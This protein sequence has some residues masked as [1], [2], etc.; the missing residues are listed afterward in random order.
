MMVEIV[1]TTSKDGTLDAKKT[2]A[3]VHAWRNARMAN[4]VQV[5]IGVMKMLSQRVLVM[6]L[7]AHLVEFQWLVGKVAREDAQN[8][9]KMTVKILEQLWEIMEM[10]FVLKLLKVGFVTKTMM[11]VAK[12]PVEI[13]ARNLVT[14]VNLIQQNYV[15]KTSST[16]AFVM[17]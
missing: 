6:Q 4:M 13:F 8:V 16:M 10:I 3:I 17:I 14:N 9:I 1:V 12:R 11:P 7:A 2:M 5:L 15:T